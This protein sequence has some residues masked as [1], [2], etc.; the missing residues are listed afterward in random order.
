MVDG[1]GEMML[2]W[3][4]TVVLIQEAAEAVVTAFNNDR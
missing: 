2:E 3:E 1:L 4:T